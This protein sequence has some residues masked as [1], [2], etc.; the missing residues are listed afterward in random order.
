MPTLTKVF[1]FVC[2]VIGGC[3]SPPVESEVLAIAAGESHTCA[4]IREGRVRCWGDNDEGQLG[5]GHTESIGDDEHPREAG[6]VDVGGRVTHIAAGKQHTCV[7]LEDSTVR[8]WGNNAFGQLGYGHIDAVGDNETPASEPNPVNVGG[9][10]K[11]I[12]AG[13]FHTC[14]LLQ[15]GALRCWGDATGGQL[16]YGNTD[17][18]G[19]DESPVEAGDVSVGGTVSLVG[20]GELHT[21]AL[22]EQGGVR[23]WGRGAIA[24]TEIGG[25]GQLGYGNLEN[26]GDTPETLPSLVGDVSLGGKVSLLAVGRYHNCV[27]LEDGTV[28]CWG[29]GAGRHGHGQLGTATI[30][31][32]GDNETPLEA[33]L[34]TVVG[35]T[36]KKI[37]AGEVHSCAI[38]SASDVRCW[39][40][41]GF[42]QLGYANDGD[43][44]DDEPPARA[45]AIDVGRLV[46]SLALGISHTCAL[47]N[48]RVICWGLGASGQTGYP[49]R[50][51]IGDVDPPST[52]DPVSL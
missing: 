34:P 12:S 36:P 44:G 21:C 15:S 46:D 30:E 25:F 5:Y 43:V 40:F 52:L 27:V 47:A 3:G 23:C 4:I 50:F 26:V 37:Y 33:D 1:L 49:S 18:I 8:C 31:N 9:P 42:G 24:E 16:G 22:L 19:D 20:C 29:R 17:R 41:G 32:I 13:G 7:L 2:V 28:R 45:G 35:G 14:A 11:Q 39:G 51:T 10:V 38:L 48:Q 6:D